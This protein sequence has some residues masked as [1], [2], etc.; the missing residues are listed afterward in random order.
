MEKS[1]N[2][3]QNQKAGLRV[4]RTKKRVHEALLELLRKGDINRISIRELCSLAEIN[5]TTFYN[6]YG[7]QYDVLNEMAEEYIR[8]TSLDVMNEI[9]SGRNIAGAL[10]EAL[11]YTQD[12]LSFAQILLD[13]GHYDLMG[14]LLKYMPRF[15]EMVMRN[16]PAGIEEDEKRAIAVFTEYGAVR[17]LK[18]WIMAGCLKSPQEEAELILRI[19][20]REIGNEGWD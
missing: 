3:G 13:A 7:S 15:D 4:E 20:G 10:K 6:H 9:A 18:E 2:M 12:H 19:A 14:Y 16:L 5:R 11:I 17:L 1:V 8:N